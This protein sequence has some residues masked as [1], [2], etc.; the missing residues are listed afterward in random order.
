MTVASNDTKL[1]KAYLTITPV[2]GDGSS[3]GSAQTLALRFNPTDYRVAKKGS[4]VRT[5]AR[6]A[7]QAGPLQ[8]RGAQPSRMTLTVLL[9]ASDST[10][11]S[12]LA[13]AQTLLSCCSPT[14]ESLSRN[15]PCAPYVRFGWGATTG[16]TAVVHEVDVT[17][18]LFR[19]DGQP[20]RATATL[21][22]EEVDTPTARQNPTSGAKAATRSHTVVAGDR[23]PLIAFR[24]YGDATRWRTIAEANDIDDP[25][26]LHPGTTL[27]VPP[28]AT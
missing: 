6:S 8:W 22:L 18:T 21:T 5:A 10:T 11:G 19:N 16:F 12:V 15:E 7:K 4:W 13:D 3:A 27:L 24:M 2:A 14:A 20:C 25:L 17:F 26:V 23:L 1:E 28:E 9:D